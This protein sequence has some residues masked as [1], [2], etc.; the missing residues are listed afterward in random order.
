MTSGY[1]RSPGGKTPGKFWLAWLFLGLLTAYGAEGLSGEP[2]AAPATGTPA[3]ALASLNTPKSP[4]SQPQATVTLEPFYLLR[5]EGGR[6]WVERCLVT[7]ELNLRDQPQNIDLTA[8]NLRAVIYGFLNS[9]TH[10]D[11]L[12][13]K[14]L[15]GINNFLKRKV[16]ADVKVSRSVL[17]LR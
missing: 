7:L 3:P 16:V 13:P 12:L 15:D 17:L 14:T 1:P 10:L 4:A 2:G 9:E 11:E 5:E 8:A 6:V